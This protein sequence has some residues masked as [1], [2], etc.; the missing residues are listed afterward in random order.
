MAIKGVLFGFSGTLFRIEQA[1][2]GMPPCGRCWTWGLGPGMSRGQPDNDVARYR[3]GDRRLGRSP[4][5]PEAAAAPE[6]RPLMRATSEDP[7]SILALNQS[8]QELQNVPAQRIG[9]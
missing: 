5:S 6:S 4:A 9:Q 3:Q 2:S 7:L 1:G 8:T